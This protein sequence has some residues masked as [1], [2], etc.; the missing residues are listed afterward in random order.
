MGIAS[1]AEVFNDW[2][3]NMPSAATAQAVTA[4][5]STPI[6]FGVSKLSLA[7]FAALDAKTPYEYQNTPERAALQQAMQRDPDFD[8]RFTA[9]TGGV[10][11]SMANYWGAPPAKPVAAS[12]LDDGITMA[13]GMLEPLGDSM[14]GSKPAADVQSVEMGGL[15]RSF[16]EKAAAPTQAPDPLA[17]AYSAMRKKPG[18]D[19]A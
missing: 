6:D 8:A 7:G 19:N 3:D 10:Q 15:S 4:F 18:L 9:I 14:T 12:R 5:D 16:G 11:A 2:A 13:S 17:A 1:A